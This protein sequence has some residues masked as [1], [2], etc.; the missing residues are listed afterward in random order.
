MAILDAA[1]MF[2]Q[3]Q[4][5]KIFSGLPFNS[6]IYLMAVQKQTFYSEAWPQPI[7]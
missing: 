3:C 6:C 1:W 5:S 4:I 2:Q 7:L